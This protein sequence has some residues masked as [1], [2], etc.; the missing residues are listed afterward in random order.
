MHAISLD[1]TDCRILA[2]LQQEGRISNLDLAERISLSP[3][4]CLR[5]MRLLEE[6]GVIECYRACL[7]REKLGFELE[8]FVQVSMRNDQEQW[9]ERFAE[10]LKAWPEVVSAFV[11]TGE[12]HYLLRVLAHNLKHYSDFVLNQLYK[13]PGVMDIRSNIVLQTLKDEAGA[14]VS[15]ARTGSVRAD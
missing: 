4:A 15:L 11:V 9:H 12:T 5:R 7:S 8:A 14:P 10:A 2:V 6:Q 13:A 1:A 3:S